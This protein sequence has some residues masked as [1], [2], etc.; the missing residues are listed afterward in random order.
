MS[1]VN[2]NQL[3]AKLDT[4][5]DRSAEKSIQKLVEIGRPAI[6]L[7]MNAVQ[8]GEN[9][10]IRKWSLQAIG[11]IGDRRGAPLLIEALS[12]P[13]MTIR[14]HA[15]KGLARMKYKKAAK[16]IAKLLKDNSGGVRV[17]ALYALAVLKDYSV[18]SSICRAL[19]DEKWYV[20]QAAATACGEL[21]ILKSKRLLQGLVKDDTKMAVRVSASE[22]LAKVTQNL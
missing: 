15:I 20:R 9:P 2:I 6:P 22:A 16:E 1:K 10:K 5:S 4:S 11:A 18:E 8:S 21:S 13:K 3:I 7:L 19:G 12:D 14:L 17:N